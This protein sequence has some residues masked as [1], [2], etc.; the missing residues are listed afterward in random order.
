MSSPSAMERLRDFSV[1]LQNGDAPAALAAARDA[2]LAEPNM[3]EAHYAF[4]QAWTA[5]GEPSRAEQAFATAIRL[6]PGFADAWVNLGS[7]ATA[8]AR[9]NTPSVPW[10]ARCRRSPAI[11][12]QAPTSPPYCA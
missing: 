5:A 2:C 6:R 12:R 7:L 1:A 10:S 3:P 11:L 4:G 8:R 9:W